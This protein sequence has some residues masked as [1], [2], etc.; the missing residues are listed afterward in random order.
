LINLV[1]SPKE[2]S[3]VPA[4]EPGD[5]LLTLKLK[6]PT[7]KGSSERLFPLCLAV[8]SVYLLNSFIFSFNY[9]ISS[10]VRDLFSVLEVSVVLGVSV[11]LASEVFTDSD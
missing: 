3:I 10:E 1:L 6:S 2:I 4:F 9:F 8:P 11:A 5:S 7:L